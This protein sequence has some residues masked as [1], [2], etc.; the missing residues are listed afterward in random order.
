MNKISWQTVV[1]KYMKMVIKQIQNDHE[2][3][4]WINMGTGRNINVFLPVLEEV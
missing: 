3:I 1:R 2:L 4:K